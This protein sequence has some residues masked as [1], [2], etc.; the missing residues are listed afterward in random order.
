MLRI[1]VLFAVLA[2]IASILGF[3]G[4]AGTSANLA[5]LFAMVFL[6]LFVLSLSF[7]GRVVGG[8]PGTADAYSRRST[9]IDEAVVGGSLDDRA[10]CRPRPGPPDAARVDGSGRPA[11]T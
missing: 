5:Y 1:A 10:I 3:S 4:A 7:G 2:V 8:G 9:L 11:S 6:V